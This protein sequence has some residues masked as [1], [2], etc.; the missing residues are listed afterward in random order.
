MEK[1][2]KIN[3]KLRDAIGEELAKHYIISG[4][5]GEAKKISLDRDYVVNQLEA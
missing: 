1:I 3:R 5:K 2:T 4:E